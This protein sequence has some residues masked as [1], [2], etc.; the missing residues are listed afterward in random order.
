MAGAMAI[1]S[2]SAKAIAFVF[3][4][5]FAFAKAIAVVIVKTI[6]IAIALAWAFWHPVLCRPMACFFRVI[7][8]PVSLPLR[9]RTFARSLF[10]TKNKKANRSVK[11]PPIRKT[12]IRK[13]TILKRQKQKEKT[14]NK[15]TKTKI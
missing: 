12:N 14:K 5:A 9:L 6:A 1:V 3:V 8:F 4:T 15:N 2:V 11:I 7:C 10:P 13:Q